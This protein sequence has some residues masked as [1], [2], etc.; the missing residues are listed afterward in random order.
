MRLRPSAFLTFFLSLAALLTWFEGASAGHGA[1]LP[2]S[3]AIL[4]TQPPVS[5]ESSSVHSVPPRHSKTYWVSGEPESIDL[6]EEDGQM[7]V[8][9]NIGLDLQPVLPPTPPSLLVAIAPE[10][11]TS[12]FLSLGHFRC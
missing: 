4:A 5:L 12:L 10:R 1:G 6:D 9:A 7:A 3:S 11:A 8:R 2:A